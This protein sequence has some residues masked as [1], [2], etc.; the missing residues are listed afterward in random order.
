[1]VKPHVTH[2]K[3][4]IKEISK[5]VVDNKLQVNNI[6]VSATTGNTFI[7]YPSEA[8]RDELKSKLQAALEDHD[9][10]PL[11]D[12]LPSISIVGITE[13]EWDKTNV[14]PDG[15]ANLMQRLKDQNPDLITNGESFNILFMKPPNGDYENFQIVAR[16]STKIRDTIRTNW[17]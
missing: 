17:S 1:M 6:G 5:I 9:M 3:P 4:D 14:S 2:G 10:Q 12:M 13:N 7:N 15:I 11:S 16:V 8:A